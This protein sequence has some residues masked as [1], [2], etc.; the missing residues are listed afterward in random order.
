MYIQTKHTSFVKINAHSATKEK[1][2]VINYMKK[3]NRTRGSYT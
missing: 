2:L 1:G 3:K